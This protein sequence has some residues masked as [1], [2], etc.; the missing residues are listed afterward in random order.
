MFLGTSDVINTHWCVNRGERVNNLFPTFNSYKTQ[1]SDVSTYYITTHSV[2]GRYVF[3]RPG[4]IYGQ[5]AQIYLVN[6]ARYTWSTGP[7][8][9][10]QQAQTYLVNMA[11]Y[12]FV[13]NPSP[14]YMF[15]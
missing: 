4:Y 15:S 3:N 11:I 2:P 12:T 9:P 7:D 14:M 6:R 10:G 5:Q 8:I 1:I 13:S